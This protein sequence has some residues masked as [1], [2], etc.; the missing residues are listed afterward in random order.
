MREYPSRTDLIRRS[1]LP[2]HRP[3]GCGREMRKRSLNP[4]L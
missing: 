1:H 4:I 2:V 3:P